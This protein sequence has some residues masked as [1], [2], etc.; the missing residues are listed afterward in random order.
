MRISLACRASVTVRLQRIQRLSSAQPGGVLARST[1]L[2]TTI[3]PWEQSTSPFSQPHPPHVA[4]LCTQHRPTP[5]ASPAPARAAA[6]GPQ[7]SK[8]R[9]ATRS[10]PIP[11]AAWASAA[12]GG[13]CCVQAGHTL[14]HWSVPSLAHPCSTGLSASLAAM[15]G[16]LQGCLAHSGLRFRRGLAETSSQ[17]P[18]RYQ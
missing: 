2:Y 7:G 16:G 8:R 3:P 13:C 6:A 18:G 15:G 14:Q 12:A 9:P 1:L 11:P 10:L 4:T 5:T 17:S